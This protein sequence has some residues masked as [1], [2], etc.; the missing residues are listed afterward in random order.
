MSPSYRQLDHWT[1]RGWLRPDNGCT[2]GSGRPRRWSDAELRV[3][4]IISRLRLAGIEMETAVRVARHSGVSVP[5][6]VTLAPGI[7]ISVSTVFRS[8][9]TIKAGRDVL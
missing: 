9:E 4:D 7:V 6:E 2:P 1:R 8:T 5:Y 3:A